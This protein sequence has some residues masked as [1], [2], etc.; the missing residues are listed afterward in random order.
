MHYSSNIE[1]KAI[2]GLFIH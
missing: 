1:K 2:L